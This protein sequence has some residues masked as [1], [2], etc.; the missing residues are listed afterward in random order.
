MRT[1]APPP[2]RRAD[3]LAARAAL[4][5]RRNA[6]LVATTAAAFCLV[7][8]ALLA[9]DGNW[10]AFGPLAYR[11]IRRASPPAEALDPTLL[12]AIIGASLIIGLLLGYALNL[13]REMARPRLAGAREAERVSGAPMIAEVKPPAAFMRA[14]DGDER[15][16]PYRL[17]YLSVSPAGARADTLVL[18]G[19]D[20]SLVTAIAVRVARAAASDARATLVIDL[21]TERAPA[22]RYYGVRSEP[23]FTDAVVGVR[24]WREV[25]QSIGANE[26]LS[27][28]FIPCGALRRDV[29]AHAR[30]AEFEEFQREHDFTVVVAPGARAFQRGIALFPHAP[31]MLCV[32]REVT[33]LSTVSMWR[34][35]FT[36][37]RIG[38]YGLVM[39]N[40]RIDSRFGTILGH[41]KSITKA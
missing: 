7:L 15:I 41:Y 11:V 3:W 13:A 23:G 2:Y 26:G 24:L 39:A 8:V 17:V 29:A 28:D 31:C 27:I 22:S 21:D 4:A 6:R 36:E 10:K 16:D 32:Q 18:T 19:E 14:N 35:R 33:T 37:S 34:A 20:A 9:I 1:L 25:A 12:G 40:G 38:L 30:T 5:G